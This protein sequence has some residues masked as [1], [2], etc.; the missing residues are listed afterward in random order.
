MDTSYNDFFL[1]NFN[2]VARLNGN[3]MHE[4]YVEA[5]YVRLT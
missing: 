1:L 4:A 5:L 3:G 2:G